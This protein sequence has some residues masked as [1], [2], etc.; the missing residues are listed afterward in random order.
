MSDID[1]PDLSEQV[2]PLPLGVWI[3][4]IGG[5]LVVAYYINRRQGSRSEPEPTDGS[6]SVL[7]GAGLVHAPREPIYL[8]DDSP[9]APAPAP[10]TD[11]ADAITDNYSW[12][13]AAVSWHV[14]RGVDALTA[15]DAIARYLSGEPLTARQRNLV[16]AAIRQLGPPPQPVPPIR[17]ANETKPR[18]PAPKKPAPKPQP[19]PTPKPKPKAPPK[20]KRP[21]GSRAYTIRPG[22][23][24]WDI[25]GRFYGD[26]TEWPRI[27]S[28]SKTDLRSGSPHLIYPGEVVTIPR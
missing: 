11:A 25:A 13:R 20:P 9:T 17:H 4:A 2:G 3:L 23:T 22:D 1:L 12:E 7:S 27:W 14:E 6:G 15:Q 21:S 5:G 24:L 10:D 26:P 18:K 8:V 16:S 19:K 28:A